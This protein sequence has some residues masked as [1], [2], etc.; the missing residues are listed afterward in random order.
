MFSLVAPFAYCL[1]W[2]SIWGGIG[3][4][5]SR[6]ALELQELGATFFNNSGHFL[7]DGSEYCYDVPQDQIVV[8]GTA[9]FTNRLL[10][11]TP[12]CIFDEITYDTA[13]FRVLNSFSFPESFGNGG[14][15]YFLS[16]LFMFTCA[17]FFMASAGSAS[18][19]V[20]K[21]ASNGRKNSHLARRMFWLVTVGALATALLSSGGSGAVAV[22]QAAVIVCGLPCVILLCYLMQSICL[23][24]QGIENITDSSDYTF[25]DQAEFSIPIYGGIFN[26][27]EYLLSCG[28]V[29]ASRVELQMDRVTRLQ[30]VEF[31]KGVFVPFVS[32][33]QILTST[34]KENIKTNKIV[35]TFYALSYLTWVVISLASVSLSGLRGVS[36]ALFVVNGGFLAFIRSAFRACYTLR[37]NAI[38]DI[39]TSTI[40]WPQVLT[41]LRL[42]CNK[43]NHSG[44]NEKESNVKINK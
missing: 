4:R 18:L 42:Q 27:M 43:T 8:E 36:L 3:L 20:D 25:P 39:V 26:I 11:V 10:G 34:Y 40:L 19:V 9:I 23:L 31:L 7:V 35:V 22:V 32:L 29:N 2:F 24:C 16:V 5:Q 41:Q 13:I 44:D 21:M 15:G 28:K 1:V 30:F 14:L 37:S 38:G 17:C 33:H 6:Q 12:V